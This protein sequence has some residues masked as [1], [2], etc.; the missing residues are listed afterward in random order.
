MVRS[1]G[2]WPR[3]G[4]NGQELWGMVRSRGEWPGV[5]ENGL[6]SGRMA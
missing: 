6:E 1:R 4:E 2:E 5:G 3:V